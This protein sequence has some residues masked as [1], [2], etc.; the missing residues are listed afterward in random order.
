MVDED[1]IEYAKM[2]ARAR[3]FSSSGESCPWTVCGFRDIY[4]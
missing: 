3:M 2:E 1:R 4:L